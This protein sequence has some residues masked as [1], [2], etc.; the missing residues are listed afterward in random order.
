MRKI[1]H[2]RIKNRSEQGFTLIELMVVIV[3]IGLLATVVTVNVVKSGE[4]A[5]HTKARADIEALAS[6]LVMFK[7]DNGFYPETDPGLD[8][9]LYEPTVGREAK[10]WQGPYLMKRTLPA[11]PWQNEYIY[12]SPGL[13]NPDSYDL[14]S[15]G[16][17]GLEGGEGFDRDILSWEYD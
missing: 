6:A 10:N 12:I 16:A 14:Y 7:T 3:I 1:T 4:R 2:R 9:L 8:A 17:D 11:D 13:T 5:K 15:L